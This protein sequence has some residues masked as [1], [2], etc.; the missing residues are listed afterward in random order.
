VFACICTVCPKGCRLKVDEEGDHAVTGNS[1]ARGA[2]Y[3][4]AELLHP[5]RVLTTTVRLRGGE[6]A[7][8]PVRTSAPIPKGPMREAMAVID[9]IAAEAPVTR[10]QVLLADLLGTG[11]DVVVTRSIGRA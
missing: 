8:C 10:G 9:R 5:T 1:C 11:A 7:R 3:G 2:D 6:L 4:R